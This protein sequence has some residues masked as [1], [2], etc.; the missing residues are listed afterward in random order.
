ML[1]KLKIMPRKR[2]TTC[3]HDSTLP[4]ETRAAGRKMPCAPD[5]GGLGT[6][7]AATI[8]FPL[9]SVDAIPREFP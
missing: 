5:T 3:H 6:S 4:D 9:V 2:C 1:R 7:P 8:L